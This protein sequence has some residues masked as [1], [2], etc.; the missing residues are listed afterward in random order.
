M[1]A[2]LGS[3]MLGLVLQLNWQ[4]P[5]GRDF[6]GLKP[7]HERQRGVS[8]SPHDQQEVERGLA[9]HTEVNCT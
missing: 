1:A 9:S 7:E 4:C 8:G 3:H 5:G 2:L 6:Y